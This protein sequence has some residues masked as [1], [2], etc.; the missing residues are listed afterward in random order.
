MKLKL[1]QAGYEGFTGYLGVT[2]FENG[3]SVGDVPEREARTIGMS[4]KTEWE[5]GGDPN[6]AQALLNSMHNEPVVEAAAAPV[7][8]KVYTEEQLAAI[9]DKEGIKGL[10]AIAE[11][12]GIKGTSIKELIAEILAYKPE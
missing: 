6:P 5:D 1:V 10:R 7:V 11:P 4:I 12:L 2:L 3:V 8:P 9:A